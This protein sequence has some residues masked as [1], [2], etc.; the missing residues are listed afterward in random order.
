MI[1]HAR[2]LLLNRSGGNQ[3]LKELGEEYIPSNYVSLSLPMWL[4]VYWE[5]L[6]GSSPENIYRNYIVDRLLR[7]IHAT[8]YTGYLTY[9]DKRITYDPAAIGPFSNVPYEFTWTKRSSSVPSTGYIVSV[10]RLGDLIADE[11]TGIMRSSWNVDME[12]GIATVTNTRT[13][14]R[15]VADVFSGNNISNRINLPD[16]SLGCVVRYN[17]VMRSEWDEDFRI[18]VMLE[19]KIDLSEKVIALEQQRVH[20]FELFGHNAVEPYLTFFGLWRQDILP[21]K[22]A[23]LVLAMI[24]RMNDIWIKAQNSSVR[25]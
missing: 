10:D 14:N 15:S 7:L 22:L 3:S 19:P 17:T 18:D 1:N 11:K 9:F 6:F 23:G 5:I 20:T 8:D 2:T 16:S 12:N 25:V 4:R 13:N 24:Y 21:D